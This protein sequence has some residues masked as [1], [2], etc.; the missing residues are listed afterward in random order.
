M[1]DLGRFPIACLRNSIIVNNV[2]PIVVSSCQQGK[3]VALGCKLCV[4][5][6]LGGVS[7]ARG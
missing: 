7:V 3:V 5:V 4:G 2:V 6:G 1:V